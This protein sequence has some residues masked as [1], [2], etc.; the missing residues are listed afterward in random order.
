[1]SI[2]L[3]GEVGQGLGEGGLMGSGKWF[4]FLNGFWSPEMPI[5]EPNDS[6]HNHYDD[7]DQP[8]GNFSL[9]AHP[10]PTKVLKAKIVRG[11]S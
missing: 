3:N 9:H 5:G 10:P 11:G 4:L 2:V 6:Q 1:L 7:N 8:C